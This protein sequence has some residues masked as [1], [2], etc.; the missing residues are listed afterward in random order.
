[1]I[2]KYKELVNKIN[3]GNSNSDNNSSNSDNNTSEVDKS[4]S[5]VNMEELIAEKTKMV[6]D[7]KPIREELDREK[8]LG[9]YSSFEGSPATRQQRTPSPSAK[10][11]ASFPCAAT[12]PGRGA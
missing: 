7:L 6:S 5:E 8:Y 2:K 10:D 9:S 12:A 11:G 3:S 4:V 1:M